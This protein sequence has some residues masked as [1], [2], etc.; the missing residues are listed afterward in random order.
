MVEKILTEEFD[1]EIKEF[2]EQDTFN[3]DDIETL[4]EEE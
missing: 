2:P 4:E 3:E 1:E